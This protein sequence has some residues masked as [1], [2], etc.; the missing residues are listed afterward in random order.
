V[1]SAE[2]VAAR[3]KWAYALLRKCT[4]PAPKYGSAEWLALPLRDPARVAAVVI[5][6]EC[7]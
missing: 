1:R 2:Q 6:A 3:K 7:R 5:A 4:L